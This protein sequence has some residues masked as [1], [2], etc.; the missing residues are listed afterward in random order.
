[1]FSAKSTLTSGVFSQRLFQRLCPLRR[2]R[3]QVPG[4]EGSLGVEEGEGRNWGTR[5]SLGAL[6]VVGGVGLW[7]KTVM[8]QVVMDWMFGSSFTFICPCS[9]PQYDGIWRWGPWEVIIF[10]G[11][12]ESGHHDGISALIRCWREQSSVSLF[13]LRTQEKAAV[14]KQEE[15]IY[16]QINPLTPLSWTSQLA[17]LWE[18]NACYLSLAICSILLK[19]PELTETQSMFWEFGELPH[20]LLFWLL[21]QKRDRSFQWTRYSK[22]YLK[23]YSEIFFPGMYLNWDMIESGTFF[24]LSM[25]RQR[26][27]SSER[28]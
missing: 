7:T 23:T 24:A 28:E 4:A 8:S 20:P 21:E 9:N 18:V 12:N 15:S 5:T 1:M 10:I 19:Q 13:H 26:K 6:V 3:K 14:C 25:E 27:L 16:Q 2:Q 22:G 11:G 17:E